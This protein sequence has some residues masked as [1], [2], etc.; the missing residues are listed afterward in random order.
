LEVPTPAAAGAATAEQ[1]RENTT[2]A[3][4]YMM[5]GGFASERMSRRERLRRNE[6]ER[7]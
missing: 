2:A 7:G 4:K 5:K 6:D 1:I 3:L